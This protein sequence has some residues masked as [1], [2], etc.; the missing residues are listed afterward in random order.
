[1]TIGELARRAGVADSTIRYYER[2]RLIR[3][4]GRT[5]GN[6]RYFELPT[7]D[8]LRFIRAAQA[9][10][11]SLEDVRALL[12]FRDG[13]VAPCPEVQ[14]IV[15]ARLAEVTGQLKRL[16]HLQAVLKQLRDACESAPRGTHCPVLEKLG[17][18]K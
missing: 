14:V 11:L 13:T 8:R 2:V 3:S 16:R 17:G 15:E 5:A 10:G 7:I 18:R 9:S 12:E 1:M 6:Y 4:A